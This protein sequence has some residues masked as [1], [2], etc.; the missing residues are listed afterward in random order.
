MPWVS[1]GYGKAGVSRGSL[2]APGGWN[3]CGVSGFSG[4][5]AGMVRGGLGGPGDR[6][7]LERPCDLGDPLSPWVVPV[8]WAP[9]DVPGVSLAVPASLEILG[10]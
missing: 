6:G 5:W 1:L 10:R 2:V 8:V 3:F 4:P 9:W 7:P